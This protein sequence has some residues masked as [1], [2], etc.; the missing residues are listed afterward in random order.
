MTKGSFYYI[1]CMSSIK[2]YSV[3]KGLLIDTGKMCALIL[4]FTLV[5]TLTSA[6]NLPLSRNG[7]TFG[8]V[9]KA[10]NPPPP[11]P[12]FSSKLS[13]NNQR[14]INGNEATPHSRTYQAGLIVRRLRNLFET[15]HICGG[16]ILSKNIIL[17][18]GFCIEH[19]ST[20]IAVLGAHYLFDE[21]EKTQQRF[22]LTS[23]NFIFHPSYDS[24]CMCNDIALLRLPVNAVFNAFVQPIDL[25][26]ESMTGKSLVGAVVDVAGNFFLLMNFHE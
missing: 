20:V 2:L 24:S 4:I 21:N 25:P 16:S 26:I 7:N 3:I 14:I 1:K 10:I 15:Q 5:L 23:N 17:T 12:S 6:N 9:E 13:E 11:P 22:S 19:S 18:T 8:D